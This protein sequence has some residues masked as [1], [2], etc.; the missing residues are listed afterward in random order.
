MNIAEIVAKE[1]INESEMSFVIVEFIKEMKG[2]DIESVNLHKGM[3]PPIFRLQAFH[4]CYEVA[5]NYFLNKEIEKEE[6]VNE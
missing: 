3:M 5:A 2:I 4:Q 1:T 6:I